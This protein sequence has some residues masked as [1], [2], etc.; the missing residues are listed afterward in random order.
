MAFK[1]LRRN[2][3]KYPNKY[4]SEIPYKQLKPDISNHVN[5]VN[6]LQVYNHPTSEFMSLALK[7]EKPF[8]MANGH[9][10]PLKVVR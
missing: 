5:S 6:L 8:D 4:L 2:V 10:G 1:A 9:H 3:S 7:T